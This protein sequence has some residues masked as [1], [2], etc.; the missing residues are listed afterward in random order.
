MF[1]PFVMLGVLG[2]EGLGPMKQLAWRAENKKRL[3][4]SEIMRSL[5]ADEE[6]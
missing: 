2:R 3:S 4:E 5:D 6:A 1:T